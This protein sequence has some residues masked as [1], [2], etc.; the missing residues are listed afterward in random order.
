MFPTNYQFTSDNGWKQKDYCAPIND[1]R[2]LKR[3]SVE[4]NFNVIFNHYSGGYSKF[5]NFGYCNHP[6]DE[7]N[8]AKWSIQERYKIVNIIP[9][10]WGNSGTVEFRVHPPTQSPQKVL[11]WLYICNAIL[12]YAYKNS[13]KIANFAPLTDLKLQTI[14]FDVYSSLLASK[15]LS[16]VEWRKEYMQN[17]DATGKKE[18]V[19]DL[20]KVIPYSVLS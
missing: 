2:L 19:E 15:L 1:L 17:M 20:T 6:K 13:E 10:I 3:N 7:G 4:E 9:L 11:N 18:L 16:Y 14:F 5:V 12:A 8:R